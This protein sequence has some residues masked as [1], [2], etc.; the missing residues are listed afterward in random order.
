MY[1]LEEQIF[2]LVSHV[3]EDKLWSQSSITLALIECKSDIQY[4]LNVLLETATSSVERLRISNQ[5]DRM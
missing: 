2:R 5:L 4:G 1:I 3:I